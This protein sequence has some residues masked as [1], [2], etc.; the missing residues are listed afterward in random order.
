MKYPLLSALILLFI[1]IGT[2]A[3]E[4]K[5][6]TTKIKIGR[7][8]ST[9]IRPVP[10][11]AYNLEEL[12]QQIETPRKKRQPSPSTDKVLK[13]LYEKDALPSPRPGSPKTSPR[14]ISGVTSSRL[15]SPR[16]STISTFCPEIATSAAITSSSK[17]LLTKEN[18]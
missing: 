18:K 4:K 7:S 9:P 1:V 13:E 16:R 2:S 14:L 15:I 5:L 3:M 12:G 10:P 17:I 6:S 11:L 8:N